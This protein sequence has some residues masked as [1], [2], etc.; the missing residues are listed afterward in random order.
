MILRNMGLAKSKIRSLNF[1]RANFPIFKELLDGILWET[2]L[3]D[4]RKK[5]NWRLFK[6]TFLT[7]L[8]L[9]IPQHKKLSGGGSKSAWLINDP[10]VELRDKSD[11]CR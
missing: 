7:A 6:D 9:S 8:E 3:R 4:K 5:Q 1:R 2:V 11:T 10:L